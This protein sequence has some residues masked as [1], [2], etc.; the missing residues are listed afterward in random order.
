MKQEELKYFGVKSFEEYISLR[1]LN[2][3]YAHAKEIVKQARADTESEVPS[4]PLFD[5]F[6]S[7]LEKEV[8][9]EHKK[10]YQDCKNIFYR[11]SLPNMMEMIPEKTSR[12]YISITGASNTE[13]ITNLIRIFREYG[14]DMDSIIVPTIGFQ[15]MRANLQGSEEYSMRNPHVNE[16]KNLLSKAEGNFFPMLHY[17]SSTEKGYADEI[18]QLMSV[19]NPERI[20]ARIQ[21]N[22]RG[23]LK[24]AEEL[25]KAK[26]QYPW[27]EMCLQVPPNNLD[28]PR[29]KVV[30]ALAEY[31]GVIDSIIID[32][33]RGKG[34]KLPVD[35]VVGFY[36]E[37]RAA[38]PGLS[39][40]IAGGLDGTV[41]REEIRQMTEMVGKDFSVDA[42]GRLRDM[43]G[44][45]RGEDILNYQKAEDYVKASVDLLCRQAFD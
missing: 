18:S 33:S 13:D 41:V 30:E 16:I 15:V 36:R 11:S 6:M 22:N 21:V 40:V 3:L 19:C 26:E 24:P 37:I 7:E 20:C 10:I 17:N 38:L 14:L 2:F 1:V 34:E 5:D 43:V 29:E 44:E 12:N 8:G 39:I 45:K 42:E 9:E 35:D 28:V 32:D 27:L 23:R 4:V 25:E 31:S